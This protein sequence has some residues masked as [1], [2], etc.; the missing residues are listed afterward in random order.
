MESFGQFFEL[1]PDSPEI[2]RLPAAGPDG[3]TAGVGNARRRS[4]LRKRNRYRRRRGPGPY[5]HGSNPQG[6]HGNERSAGGG[7]SFA[8]HRRFGILAPR[9]RRLNALFDA[10]RRPDD[11]VQGGDRLPEKR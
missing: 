8:V 11:P 4:A 2:P 9:A 6:N 1:R 10:Y 7:I 3:Q 5:Y